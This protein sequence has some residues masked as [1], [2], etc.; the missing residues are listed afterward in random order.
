MN[1][2]DGFREYYANERRTF[3]WVWGLASVVVFLCW[4]A[5]VLPFSYASVAS[6]G[7]VV[8]RHCGSKGFSYT[9]NYEVDGE[10][11]T[12]ESQWGGWDGSGPCQRL[13]PG[14]AVPITYRVDEPSRSMGGTVGSWSKMLVKLWVW[15]AILCFVI[16]PVP[17]YIKELRSSG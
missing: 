5:H 12:G 14:A 1:W 15:L 9:Y 8:A 2:L 4:F 7:I 3:A 17:L 11:Y 16:V 6:N 13:V 10:A